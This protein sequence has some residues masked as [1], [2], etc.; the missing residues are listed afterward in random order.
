[1][2]PSPQS[3][4]NACYYYSRFDDLNIRYVSYHFESEFER[5]VEDSSLVE[6]FDSLD[7]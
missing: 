2:L 3:E 5:D 7:D 1:M 4:Q 6:F